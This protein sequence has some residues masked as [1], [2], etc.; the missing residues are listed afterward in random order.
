MR[1]HSLN[2]TDVK[3]V[4]ALVHQGAIDVLGPVTDPQTV[5]QSKFSMGTVLG[6]VAVLNHAGLTEFDASFKSPEV[7]DF[8]NKV[9]MELDIE[10][11][12]AYP[13]QWIGKVR[14]ET[15]DGR[16][17]NGRVDEPKGDPGNTLSRPELEDKATRLARDH[18]GASELEM[19]TVIN[20]VW[21]MANTP[22]MGQLMA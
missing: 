11:D 12:T 13:A 15:V 8:H 7:V 20:R 4:T 18:D 2:A 17:L 1:T 5:H 16:V 22:A 10:V 19:R 14:V 3:H 9:V 21:G 6:L